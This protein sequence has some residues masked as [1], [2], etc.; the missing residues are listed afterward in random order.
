MS[1]LT[2]FFP[3]ATG[4]SGGTAIGGFEIIA[5]PSATTFV[6]GQE[7]YTAA[8]GKVWIRTAA[9]LTDAGSWIIF[10]YTRKIYS[11]R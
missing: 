6:T 3:G 2:D 5:P 10:G 8:D 9:Q 1:N 4:G 11:S 7:V